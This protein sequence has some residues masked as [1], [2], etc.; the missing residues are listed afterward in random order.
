MKF[1]LLL[2]LGLLNGVACSHE[3]KLENSRQGATVIR[4]TYSDGQPFAFE[5]YELY[6]PGKEIPE[7]V[8]RTNTQGQVIFLS[9]G[10]TEWRL[11]AYSADG[12]GVD[13]VLEISS[14]PAGASPQAAGRLPRWILFAFGL[15]T[16]FGLFGTVQLFLRKKES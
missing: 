8:G 16:V 15:A 7:Q 13:Q 4:L 6:V 2:L 11:K 3:V 10:Q 12:H 1:S 9:G 14:A 5:A